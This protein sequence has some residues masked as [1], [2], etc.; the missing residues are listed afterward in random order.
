MLWFLDACHPGVSAFFPLI[1]MYEI[2]F[3]H[4]QVQAITNWSGSDDAW[5]HAPAGFLRTD[6]SEKPAYKALRAKIENEWRTELMSRTNA[7]GHV[8]LEGFKGAYQVECRG[9]T[10]AFTLDGKTDAITI[11]V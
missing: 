5:L 4:P 1:E 6:N 3:A 10:T 7:D 9:K 11:S 2:L 8:K